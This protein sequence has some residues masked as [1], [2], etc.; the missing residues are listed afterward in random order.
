MTLAEIDTQAASTLVCD[1]LICRDCGIIDRDHSRMRVGSLCSTC[2]GVSKAG[3]LPFPQN[4]RT[5][6]DLVQQAYHS[7][8]PIGPNS[9]PQVTDIG[10]VILFCTLREAL[11]NSFLLTHLRSQRVPESLLKKLLSDNKLAAQKFNGLFPSVVGFRWEEAVEA[12]SNYGGMDF[13]SASKLMR[14]AATIRNE[15]LHDGRGWAATREFATT[16]VNAMPSLVALF[17]ALHNVYIHPM[18][19]PLIFLIDIRSLQATR[20]PCMLRKQTSTASGMTRAR[21]EVDAHGFCFFLI[22]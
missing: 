7:T 22:A 4:V 21:I 1:Y 6:V 16:C 15:F 8:A 12:A 14:E 13:A 10:T 3:R 20:S 11:L 19:R 5:L 18:Q 2:G 17:V 9:N